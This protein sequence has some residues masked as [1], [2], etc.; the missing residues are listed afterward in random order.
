MNASDGSFLMDSGKG[1]PHEIDGAVLIPF[2]LATGL[3]LTDFKQQVECHS[4]RLR[5]E[6][7]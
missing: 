3:D 6:A 7:K 2:L 1:E 4:F 5:V